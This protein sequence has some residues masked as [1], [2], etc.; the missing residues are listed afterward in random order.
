MGIVIGEVEVTVTIVVVGSE[1]N[2]V[3]EV[4]GSESVIAALETPA[5][6]Y[7]LVELNGKIDPDPEVEVEAA[8]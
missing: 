5:I 4:T 2:I 1:E 8:F 6:V 7:V 3:S